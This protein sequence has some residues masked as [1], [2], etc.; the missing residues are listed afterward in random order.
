MI[1]D[2]KEGLPASVAGLFGIAFGLYARR[3]ALYASLALLGIAVEIIVN[4]SYLDPGLLYGLDIVLT[5]FIYATVSIGVAYDLAGK[6]ADWSRIF[7]AA[8][9]RWGVV[10]LIGLLMFALNIIFLQ[11]LLEPPDQTA[12]GLVTIVVV[13][14]WA[15][16]WMASVV[17][18]IEPA[19]SRWM[20][21]IVALGKG[22]G[23]STRFVNLGR[24]MILS[25]CL[26]LPIIVSILIDN[27]LRVHGVSASNLI[28]VDVPI[29]MI[30]L[31]PLQ[32]VATVFYVDF[33]RRAKR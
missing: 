1:G 17:A 23:V 26:T 25:L 2:N 14:L 5:A 7:T 31:G 6:E 24:L 13:L 33:L 27:A 8:A 11:L 4:R 28:W 3:F 30:T 32:A 12:G 18:A 22:F 10:G 16:T 19:K 15:A 9:L 29:E 20:L 21:P